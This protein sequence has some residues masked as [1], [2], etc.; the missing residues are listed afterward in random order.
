MVDANKIEAIHAAYNIATGDWTGWDWAQSFAA[1]YDEDGCQITEVWDRR[2]DI[3]PDSAAAAAATEYADRCESDAEGAEESAAEAMKHIEAG[4]LD[5]ALRAAESASTAE[6]VYGDD[7][8]W[9]P[10]RR[11]IED[12]L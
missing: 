10:F 12:A 4:D 1:G 9:G 7:P 6:C 2:S 5:K 3:D 8:T 11:A